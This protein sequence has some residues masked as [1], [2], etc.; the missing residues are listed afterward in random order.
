MKF[1]TKYLICLWKSYFD[2]GMGLTHY[3]SYF[4]AFFA[5]ASKDMKSVFIVGSI[6]AII[7][8]FVGYYWFKYDWIQAEIEVGNQYNKFVKEVREKLKKKKNL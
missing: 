4:I 7:S 5:L 8:F 1:K 3:L 6:Y 2:K